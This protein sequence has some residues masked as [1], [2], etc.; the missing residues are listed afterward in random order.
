MSSTKGTSRSNLAAIKPEPKSTTEKTLKPSDQIR[1][2]ATKE[3][4]LAF[5]G[6]LGCGI[7]S[8]VDQTK[9]LLSNA[10]YEVHTIKI[11][12]FIKEHIESGLIQLNDQ[13]RYKQSKAGR[14]ERLQDGGNQLR[15]R[16]KTPDILAEFAIKHIASHRTSQIPVGSEIT[17]YTPPRVAYLVDQL[18]HDAEVQLLRMVYGNM[19]YLVGVISVAEKRRR[20]LL[21]DN[22]AEAE[23]GALMERDRK[24]LDDC[25][26]A[27]KFGQQLEKTLQ[28]ADFFIRNDHPNSDCLNEQIQRFINLIQSNGQI[29]C[30]R[31]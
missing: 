16:F 29:L 24:E 30:I 5:S 4:V 19:F 2:R 27:D 13:E 7:A 1:Q 10:G 9:A 14:Y 8:V 28:L 31:S 17:A 25:G 23:V 6:P 18:K 15:R 12:N 22:V 21:Q 11:S 26:N 20:R 3:L